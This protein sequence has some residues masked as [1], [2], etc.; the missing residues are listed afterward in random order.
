MLQKQML[1]TAIR[2]TGKAAGKSASTLRY[3]V[4]LLL[5]GCACSVAG[6]A[7][8]QVATGPGGMPVAAQTP[9]A[10]G[11]TFDVTEGI[12]ETDNVFQT[13][14]DHQSQ[15]LEM[16]GLDF[17]LVRTGSLL[18]ADLQ[19]NFSYVDYLQG[20]Y[21]PQFFGRFDGL[22]SVSL[23]SDHL[24]WTLQD[25][26]GDAQVDPFT[27]V[28]P[29]NLE[30]INVVMTGPDFTVRPAA[31]TTVQVGAR[32]AYASYQVSPLDGYRTIESASI[33][34]DL[35]GASNVALLADFAQLRY[36]NTLV[37]TDY[38]RTRAYLQYSIAGARTQI[39]VQAGEAQANDSG[40]WI[41]TPIGEFKLTRT[42]SSLA[43][44]TFIASRQLTDTASS[45]GNLRGGAG[46][47][48]AVGTAA[49][50]SGDYLANSVSTGM[51]LGG[52]RTKVALTASWERD[53]YTVDATQNVTLGDLEL[54]VSRTLSELITADV[55]GAVRQTRYFDQDFDETDYS[56]GA[57]ATVTAGRTLSFAIRYLH[58]FRSTSGGGYGY[59]ENE[60]MVRV[61]WQPLLRQSVRNQ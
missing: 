28:T 30:R 29:G 16:T 24:K 52:L 7:Q 19:G 23:L 4:G 3:C 26:Y 13:P 38:D 48:I 61:I 35:S 22:S 56:I 14:S 9:R 59:A 32:Y 11:T 60:A 39:Q 17:G 41:H 45:F 44:L 54:R 36:S 21:D 20:A 6:I 2:D 40:G 12:G 8:A 42:L 1:T 33:T 27:P 10:Q 47:G 58:D 51:S 34:R 53:T 25:D 18:N 37:N 49:T 43:T 15:T 5:I 46:G 55:F 57:E 50:N 31:N